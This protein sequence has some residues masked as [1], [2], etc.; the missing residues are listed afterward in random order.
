MAEWSR[1]WGN[2]GKGGGGG[3]SGTTGVLPVLLRRPWSRGG[4]RAAGHHDL[5]PWPRD[6]HRSASRDI[7]PSPQ[8]WDG[9]A[10]SPSLTAWP[11]PFL[12][13]LF[14]ALPGPESRP[15]V[16]AAPRADCP[17]PDPISACPHNPP[18]PSSHRLQRTQTAAQPWPIRPRAQQDPISHVE[19][20]DFSSSQRC[21]P[22]WLQ[23]RQAQG[24]GFLMTKKCSAPKDMS[25]W[26]NRKE[27]E[28][29]DFS[30]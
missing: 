27:A 29:N 25:K 19:A 5:A 7:I 15:E 1:L 10:W 20:G 17:G 13:R 2:E 16:W 8:R 24:P 6:T 4:P 12:D 18:K 14:V 23:R 3:N 28:I 11:C 26:P 22:S 9:C 30:A 21:R